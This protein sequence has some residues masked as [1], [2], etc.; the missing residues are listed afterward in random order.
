MPPSCGNSGDGLLGLPPISQ[1]WM[2]GKFT[3]NPYILMVKNMVSCRFSLIIFLIITIS[4]MAPPSTLDV[5]GL[6]HDLDV[7][8]VCVLKGLAGTESLDSFL[9]RVN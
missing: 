7:S 8:S 5:M 9:T 4:L 6:T 1:N 3:G 2:M